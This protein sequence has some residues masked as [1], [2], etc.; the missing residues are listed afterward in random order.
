M[1]W[2][3]V[4]TQAQIY[5]QAI[6]LIDLYS[7]SRKNLLHRMKET[8]RNSSRRDRKYV[9]PFLL[10]F[11]LLAYTCHLFDYFPSQHSLLSCHPI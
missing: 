4:L 6:Y 5:S 8:K 2:L 7:H 1:T 9:R 11:I 3:I 10:G